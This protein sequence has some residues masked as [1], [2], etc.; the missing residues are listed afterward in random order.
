MIKKKTK[1]VPKDYFNCPCCKQKV[2]TIGITPKKLVPILGFERMCCA[3]DTKVRQQHAYELEI[4][5]QENPSIF[6]DWKR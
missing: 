2:S 5:L 4:A 6:I 1:C 3:C